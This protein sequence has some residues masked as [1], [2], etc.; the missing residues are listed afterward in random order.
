MK[1]VLFIFLLGLLSVQQVFCQRSDYPMIGAQVF[2]EP[3][4]TS[5]QIE[6]MF[7]ILRE[8]HM[9]ICRIR[10]FENHMK[11]ED[12][13]WDFSLYDTA[14]DAARKRGIKVFATLFPYKKNHVAVEGFRFPDTEEQL[15]SIA[16]YIEAMVSHFGSHPALYVWVLQNEPGLGNAKKIA[17]ETSLSR[18]H[19]RTWLGK[20]PVPDY[21]NGYLKDELL[22]ERFLKDYTTWY[23]SWLSAQ[24]RRYDRVHPHHVN[25][26]GL[27]N[28]L[29]EYDF[30]RYEKFLGSLG[31]SMHA[32][33]H[34]D[35]FPREKFPLAVSINSDLIRTAAGRN[36]FWITEFQGG[37]VIYSGKVP[38]CPTAEETA[39]WIWTGVGA[40]AQ[41]V[42]FWTLN[43]R[44]SV[45]E[46]G[47]WGMLDYLKQ[48]SDRLRAAA[49]TAE[50]IGEH[51]DFFRDAEPLLSDI[52]L[53]YNPE[54]MWI[55]RAKE[56]NQGVMYDGKSRYA[57]M[58]SMIGCYEALSAY[59]ITPRL[60]SMESFD[61]DSD[62]RGK[63]VVLSDLVS[64]PSVYWQKTDRFVRRGGRLIVLGLTGYFDENMHCVMLTGFPLRDTF[65]A[66]VK[67]F[68]YVEEDF[69]VSVDTPFVNLPAHMWR[70]TLACSSARS[71]GT[72]KG[73][74][75][76]SVNDCGEGRVI[77]LPSPVGLG[78]W[79]TNGDA[80]SLF[81]RVGAAEAIE[82]VP[83]RFYAPQPGILMRTLQNGR[84][85]MTVLIN[86]NRQTRAVEIRT[87]SG[88]TPETVF[89]DGTICNNLVVLGPE[90]TQV[91]RW[92]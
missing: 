18:E 48:P 26:H 84:E 66:A 34:F 35:L 7:D 29:P 24:V 60:Q 8:N 58:R 92:R 74:T 76:A 38:L 43:Q 28:N 23:L 72:E 55:Q 68:K 25:P 9:S 30:P 10:L 59:G 6:Q 5:R 52:T 87:P 11:Q 15:S 77:W 81:F 78:A 17:T 21:D 56:S 85:Y 16:A 37:N 90:Q 4:Q 27:F 44:G 80:L 70:G 82:R 62:P 67:E 69:T 31:A 45:K 88:M 75:T 54:T 46:A 51:R 61:W 40:G 39:Q 83:F 65:G 53:L 22:N 47:E 14:F 89:G 41:G 71:I 36:P 49:A 73:E 2:I 3:G 79:R 20:R 64:I 33:W 57:F 1:S 91:I 32:S 13:T 63:V 19:Y 12:G 86:K 50:A 42:I